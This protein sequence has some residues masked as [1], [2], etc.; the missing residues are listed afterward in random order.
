[1]KY[2]ILVQLVLCL[3]FNTLS[4]ERT[5]DNL[6]LNHNAF[7]K[8]LNNSQEKIYDN[9]LK[10][11]DDYLSKHPDDVSVHIEKCKFVQ[12]A[13]Y[14]EYED[15]NPNREYFDSCTTALLELYPYHPDVLVFHTTFLWGDEIKELFEKAKKSIKEDTEVWSKANLGIIYFEMASQHYF[16][17]EYNKAYS[18]MGK[19]FSYNE[20]YKSSLEYA[21]ILIELEKKE[22][23]LKVLQEGN[24]TTQNTWQ[25]SQKAKLFIQLE[26][27]SNALELYN[28]INEIDSNYINNEKLARA[29]EGVKEY[30][31]AR[32]YLVADTSMNWYREAASLSLFLHDLKHQNGDTCLSSYNAYRELGYSMD[33]LAIYR[34]KLFFAYP[35]LPWK[36][37]DIL[38]LLTMLLLLTLFIILPSIWILPVYFIGH[39]WKIIDQLKSNETF[40]GLK[41]FWWVSSGYLI[42]SFAALL[43]EPEYLNALINWT[44]YTSGITQEEEGFS[45]LIF[46]LIAAFFGFAALYKVNLIVLA[47]KYWTIGKSIAI[48]F[49]CFIAFK[50]I[51]VI[52]MLTGMKFFDITIDD[53]TAILNLLLSSQE[54]IKSLLSNY[55]N[56]MGYLI[57]GLLAPCYE[58]IIFRGVILDSCKRYLHF[59]WA[60]IIQATLFAIIHGDLFLFPVFFGF[61]ILTGIINKKSGGMLPGIVFHVINN[62]LAISVIIARAA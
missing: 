42:A 32:R 3:L 49:A 62:I 28:L 27:Y 25:L 23:A 43:I 37:H 36:M 53:L 10:K 21:R 50:I 39:K 22:E 11:Y 2:Q 5:S 7:I 61:G 46:I 18:Y 47:P 9:I 59:N 35:F 19:A 54:E 45:A 26:D 51:T 60:N 48:T 34:L 41:S 58:E 40:W 55:G 16:D 15:Y 6:T 52:Y 1:M 8:E 31:L 14:D 20:Q 38:G 13:Q 17:S 57:V 44:D 33:P 4:A 12:F 30:T 24:D 56:G 29:M